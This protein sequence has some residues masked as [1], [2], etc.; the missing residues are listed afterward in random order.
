MLGYVQEQKRN[1][2]LPSTIEFKSSSNG[3][4]SEDDIKC[5]ESALWYGFHLNNSSICYFVYYPRSRERS[6]VGADLG[7]ESVGQAGTTADDQKV[8]S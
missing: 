2:A 6:N 4:T 3:G 7:V 1:V 5:V 8:V